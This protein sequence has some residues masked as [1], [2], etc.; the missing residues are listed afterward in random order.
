MTM[1]LDRPAKEQNIE[2]QCFE[3]ESEIVVLWSFW[4]SERAQSSPAS[5]SSTKSVALNA[6][7]TRSSPHDAALK[8]RILPV[9]AP[10]P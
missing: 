3:I 5:S 4:T 1:A 10:L 9:A 8:K 2:E 6:A 7:Y